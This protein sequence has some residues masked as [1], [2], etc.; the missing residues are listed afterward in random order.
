ML[1][2]VDYGPIL[3]ITSQ[4]HCQMLHNSKEWG[5][6]REAFP[7]RQ[8]GVRLKNVIL[9]SKIPG[10]NAIKGQYK[11]LNQNLKNMHNPLKNLS[12]D[13]RSPS[14][15]QEVKHL[16]PDIELYWI[17]KKFL[18]L[19]RQSGLAR[20]WDRNTLYFHATINVWRHCNLIKQ[21]QKELGELVQDISLIEQKTVQFFQHI[22][23]TI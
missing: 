22:Y 23:S 4:L 5:L 1:H 14:L 12:N 16:N 10:T 3:L 8:I 6:L 19:V 17:K 7:S 15:C 18:A 20:W 21:I 2:S 9:L 13:V 11:L